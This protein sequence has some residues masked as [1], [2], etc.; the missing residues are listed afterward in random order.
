MFPVTAWRIGAVLRDG[1]TL[2]E[3]SAGQVGDAWRVDDAGE[4]QVHW[5][6]VVEQADAAAQYE[7]HQVDD[8]LV[9]QA[10]AQALLDDCCPHQDHVLAGG[11]RPRLL[12]GALDPA[13]DIGVGRLGGRRRVRGAPM[14]PA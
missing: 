5:F 3:D 12:D 9:E 8:E 11:C 6:G 10:S 13:C 1:A 4:F 7:G 14:V 2:F